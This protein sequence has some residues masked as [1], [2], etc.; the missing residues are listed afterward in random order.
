MILQQLQTYNVDNIEEDIQI[1][2]IATYYIA[3]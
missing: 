1:P 3:L 2:T